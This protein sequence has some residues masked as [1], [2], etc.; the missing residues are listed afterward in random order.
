MKNRTVFSPGFLVALLFAFTAVIAAPLHIQL[1]N[2]LEFAF[3]TVEL[4]RALLPAFLV[5]LAVLMLLLVV[6]P[7]RA[8]KYV[9]SLWFTLSLLLWLQGNILLWDYGALD[10]RDIDWWGMWPF[11]VFDSALWLAAIFVAIR[12]A[13]WMSRRLVGVGSVFLILIQC[14]SIYIQFSNQVPLDRFVADESE[15]FVFSS[16]KNVFVIV[17][18]GFQSDV[19]QEVIDAEPELKEEFDDFVYFRNAVSGFRQSFPSVPNML[20]AT[21]FD[22]SQPMWEYVREA[23]FSDSSLPRFLTGQGFRSGVYEHKA[24]M[25]YDPAIV[26]DTHLARD[27]S[28]ASFDILHNIDVTLFR[29]LPHF[30]KIPVYNNQLWL[31]S[32]WFGGVEPD[33]QQPG[34]KSGDAAH[35]LFTNLGERPAR[36]HFSPEGLEK[37]SQLR[38]VNLLVNN[39]RVGYEEPGFKFYHLLGTHLPIRMDRNFNYIEPERTREA[40]REQSVG[41]IR[42]AGLIL[43]SFRELGIYDDALIIFT[44]DHGMWTK[45][46]EVNI[47][48]HIIQLHG[49]NGDVPRSALPERKGTALP[50]VLVKRPGASGTMTINDAP[51]HLCDIPRTVITEMGFDGS[52]FPCASMFEVEEDEDRIRK[53]HYST[54]KANPAYSEP[55]RST[56]TVF[57]VQGFSWLDK[58]WKNTGICL[59]AADQMAGKAKGRGIKCSDLK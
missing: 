35:R 56:M 44:A 15:K 45:V 25:Y 23:Y 17:L 6:S 28:N 4:F 26:S 47:P 43:D 31:V 53:V 38:Y 55:Y 8:R 48:D 11:G 40:L 57:E 42:L 50:L 33:V 14:T 2:Q 29:Y 37:I 59:P 16:T 3:G 9:L 10:G 58:S 46:A 32:Y 51:V 41:V 39:S 13:N 52:G 49:E 27:Y 19:F 54:N 24:G 18:D 36:E 30:L 34:D 20:T 1:T 22:N 5:S 7:Q 12:Y 21:Y